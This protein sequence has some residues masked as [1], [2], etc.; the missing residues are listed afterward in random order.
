MVS[1]V[2]EQRPVPPPRSSSSSIIDER[3]ARFE[4]YQQQQQMERIS[5]TSSDQPVSGRVGELKSA[6]ESSTNGSPRD[7]LQR[8]RT[9]I[10]TGLTE[11]RRRLFEQQAQQDTSTPRRPVRFIDFFSLVGLIDLMQSPWV[12]M[13]CF[14][15]DLSTN[16]ISS[17]PP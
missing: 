13:N 12:N 8:T 9:T 10:S 14:L 5:P 3:R 16:T 7:D 15:F 17:P 4:Q 6:F 2:N 1:P 11:E